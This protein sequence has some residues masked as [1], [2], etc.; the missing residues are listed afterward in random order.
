MRRESDSVAQDVY[1][2][3]GAEVNEL[4]KIGEGDIIHSVGVEILPRA[5][6]GARFPAAT[7]GQLRMATVPLD[8]IREPMEEQRLLR[9]ARRGPLEGT[10]QPPDVARECL[11]MDDAFGKRG[12]EER[13][14]GD[15]ASGVPHQ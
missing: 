7:E 15:L 12:R 8:Q 4:R 9:Q 1:E 2:S 5:R 11:I 3:V 6:D 14:A 10:V 13:T